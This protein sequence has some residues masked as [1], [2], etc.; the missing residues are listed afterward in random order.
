VS[1][2]GAAPLAGLSAGRCL[3]PAFTSATR[4]SGPRGPPDWGA[5]LIASDLAALGITVD[6]LPIADVPSLGADPIIGD[7]A[8][9]ATVGQVVA[10]GAEAIAQGLLAGGVLPVLKHIPGHGPCDPSI[11][12]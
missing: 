6:C 8:Y 12:T 2:L 1:R 7:R 5:R 4:E 3:R 11:V 10:V 9:G